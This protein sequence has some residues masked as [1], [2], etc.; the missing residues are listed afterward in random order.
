[1]MVR[2]ILNSEL[3]QKYR[4]LLSYLFFSV[5]SA[6]IDVFIGMLLVKFHVQV[7]IANTTGVFVSTVI[8]YIM[9]TMKTFDTSI[10][11]KS[12]LV[13]IT[14]FLLGLLIQN[15]VMWIMYYYIFFDLNMELNFL[16]SKGFSLGASFFTM[17]FVR[18]EIYKRIKQ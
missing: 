10:N 11:W 13:Y 17:Y 12:V 4:I 5:I 15:L 8:H 1:M 7:I 3:Y 6:V 2:K 18:K 16:L 14:T 9:T